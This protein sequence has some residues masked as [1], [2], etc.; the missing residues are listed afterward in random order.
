MC[1]TCSWLSA[2]CTVPPS[3]SVTRWARVQVGQNFG[4]SVGVAIY[5]VF[6]GMFGVGQGMFISFGVAAAAAAVALVFTL[7]LKPLGQ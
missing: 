7:R 4:S 3:R 5:T 1:S 6:I 2:A